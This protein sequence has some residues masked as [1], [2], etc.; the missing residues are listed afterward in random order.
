MRQAIK[1]DR[2]TIYNK[3]MDASHPELAEAIRR[4]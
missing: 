2:T 3:L 4:L 1:S